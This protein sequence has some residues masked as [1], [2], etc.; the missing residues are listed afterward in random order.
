MIASWVGLEQL[1]LNTVRVFV[2][3][4]V[5]EVDA[6]GLKQRI[7]DFLAIADRH[8]ITTMF[9]L[10]DDCNFANRVPAAGLQPD[11][12][13]GVHN[14]QW[15]SSPSVEQ[16]NDPAAW[17][18]LQAYVTDIVGTF[19]HDSRVVIWDLYNEPYRSAKFVEATFQW[20]RQAEPQQPLTTCLF[21]PEEMRGRILELCDLVSF[22]NYGPVDGLRRE[23][24]ELRRHGRPVICSEWM[25]RVTGSRFQTHL[26]LFQSEK[27]G[28]WSWGL[29]AG[30]TQ[31]YYTWGSKPG[32][33]D[34][35]LWLHDILRRDGTPFSALEVRILKHLTSKPAG[36]LQCI[37]DVVPSARKQPVMWRYTLE[38]PGERWVE[39]NFDDSSWK[40][41][42]A[43]FG[44][45]Q[46]QSGCE[47]RT[48]WN[49][50]RIWMRRTFD[51]P[52]G[53]DD[54]LVL[55][56]YHDEEAEVYFNGAPATRAIGYNAAYDHF[57]LNSAGTAALKPQGNVLAVHC[58]RGSRPQFIDVGLDAIP[59]PA[60]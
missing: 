21:G 10:F 46:P 4:V 28:C 53:Y 55:A 38:D 16:I 27:V 48:A 17:P 2:N 33:P 60:D 14:S 15:V 43:P 44:Q 54:S 42:L 56:M 35:M 23:I 47:P 8:G 32:T 12:V 41:G 6:A 36:D 58:K 57:D 31:T 24:A 19:G 52:A 22:H 26:P 34:P 11:P 13:P 5:W 30:R 29:V 51:M 45:P 40:E 9:I 39:P 49:T 20:A 1:G 59:V 7:N 25:A 18:K 50:D 37:Q 3:Y